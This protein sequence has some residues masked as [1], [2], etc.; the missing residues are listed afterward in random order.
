MSIADLADLVTAASSA[1]ELNI[2][3]YLALNV[4]IEKN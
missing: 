4:K 3:N 1:L 2:D